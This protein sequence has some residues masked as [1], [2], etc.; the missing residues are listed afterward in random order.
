MKEGMCNSPVRIMEMASAFYESCVLLASS[1]LGIFR[2]L[3]EL[4]EADAVTIAGVCRLDDRGAR[5]LLDACVAVGLLTK[6]GNAYRSTPEASAFLSPGSP[7]DLS[8]AIRYN[9]DV[10]DAWGKLTEMAKTGRPVERPGLHLGEDPERTRTFVLAMHGRALGIGRAVIPHLDLAGRQRLLDVGGGP[11]TYSMLIAGAFPGVECTVID[12]PEVARIAD[13]LITQSG[14]RD[15]VRTLPGDYHQ[16]RFPD[17]NDAVIFFGVLHQETPD[18]IRGLLQRAH[19]ALVTGG[20]I[21]ILDMMTDSTHTQPK[22][23]ALFALNMALTTPHG[24]VFSESELKG[25][26]AEA[27]FNDFRCQPLP[28]P[29]PHWMASA[30]KR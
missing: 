14:M 23:S 13:E 16:V 27:G 19:A 18:A 22:F 29:M 10:Y 30:I 28:P 9:R 2:A 24:W 26:L 17:A 21:Y 4:G 20:T 7:A 5:L 1:D 15:R 3:A 12:L 8:G 6:T 11:A 25:W